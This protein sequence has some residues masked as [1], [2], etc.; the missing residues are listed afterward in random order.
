MDIVR[1]VEGK[2]R[3]EALGT[4][5]V[6]GVWRNIRTRTCDLHE[7]RE[8]FWTGRAICCGV[9]CCGKTLKTYVEVCGVFSVGG[10]G[11][12]GQLNLPEN[13][14]VLFDKGRFPRRG[15]W[16]GFSLYSGWEQ[17]ALASPLPFSLITSQKCR[18]NKPRVGNGQC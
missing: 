10:A 14:R 12:G 13:S 16:E 2:G 18:T 15:A 3:R 11:V 9:Q 8:A 7:V 17:R 4:V 1:L 6:G 5:G